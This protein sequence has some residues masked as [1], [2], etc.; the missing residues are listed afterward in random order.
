[1]LSH[2]TMEKTF[3]FY[4]E[5]MYYV[6]V[7]RPE[8]GFRINFKAQVRW[9]PSVHSGPNFFLQ[10][11]SPFSETDVMVLDRYVNSIFTHVMHRQEGR[12]NR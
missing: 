4:Y 7:Y 5:S 12:Y 6:A 3:G 9:R 1:M 8:L 10:F 11:L 2:G